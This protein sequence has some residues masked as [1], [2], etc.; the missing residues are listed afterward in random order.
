VTP[1]GALL[2]LRYQQGDAVLDYYVGAHALVEKLV[3]AEAGGA[4]PGSYTVTFTGH[5][6]RND[7][8][9]P[10][11]VELRADPAHVRLQV[12]WTQV[13]VNGEPEPKLFELPAPRGAKVVEVG[14]GHEGS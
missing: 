7:V 5:R 8:W 4:G 9:F 14:E 10:D 11:F 13:E 6:Q 2:R 1:D 12:A 3:R